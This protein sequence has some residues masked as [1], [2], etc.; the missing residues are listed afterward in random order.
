MP[1]KIKGDAV[2]LSIYDGSA[3]YEPI[4]CLTSNGLSETRNIIESQTKCDPGQIIKTEGSYTYEI[5]F[6]GEYIQTEA[7]L[8]SWVELQAKISDLAGAGV[9]TWRIT[10]GQDSGTTE[11]YGSGIFQDLELTADA[12]DSIATFS[13]TISGSGVPSTTDPN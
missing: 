12:G 13:G 10:T 2:I 6:E 5:P 11:L 4:A 9:V 8:L 3:T 7:G 1:T